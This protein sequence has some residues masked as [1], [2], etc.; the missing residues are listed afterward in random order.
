VLCWASSLG[1]RHWLT[2]VSK[3]LNEAPPLEAVPLQDLLLLP[4]LLTLLLVLAAVMGRKAG[5][6][7]LGRALH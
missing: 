4:Q 3:L 1:L 5:L 6:C 7:K 2:A